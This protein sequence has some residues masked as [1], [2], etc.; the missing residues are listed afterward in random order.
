MRRLATV[1]CALLLACSGEQNLVPPDW[2][3]NRMI[4]Q[5]RFEPFGANDFFDD[6]MAMRT[7]PPGTVPRER[8]LS[9]DDAL[10]ADGIP[11]PVTMEL[12]REGRRRYDVVCATCHGVLGDGRTVVAEN[13]ALVRPPTFHSETLRARGPGHLYR[14]ATE[15]YGMMPGYGWQLSPWERWA[16]VAYVRALQRSQFARLA[17]LPAPLQRAAREELQR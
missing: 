16:V 1:A 7:P 6:G 11:I 8:D 17:D 3:L 13:M 9:D 5:P 4:E 14:V 10:L 15:G 2:G 12:L